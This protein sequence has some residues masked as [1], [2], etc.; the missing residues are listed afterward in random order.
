MYLKDTKKVKMRKTIIILFL[1]LFLIGCSKDSKTGMAFDQKQEILKEFVNETKA[2]EILK[3]IDITDDPK[4]QEVLEF[5]KGFI[6]T[7]SFPKV[8]GFPVKS[9]DNSF[10]FVGFMIDGKE[11]TT[12]I[13]FRLK[14][15]KGSVKKQYTI[16]V[17]DLDGSYKPKWVREDY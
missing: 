13:Q 14:T 11:Y 17:E 16:I 2:E 6:G 7:I 5:I 3:P 12:I 8:D 15:M 1:I 10:K 9:D 4:K